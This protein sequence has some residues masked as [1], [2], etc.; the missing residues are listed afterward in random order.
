[1]NTRLSVPL[2]LLA[3]LAA[4]A[5][6]PAAALAD[7][8]QDNK[9]LWRNGTLAGAAAALYGLHNH[10]TTTTVLGAAG[11]AYSAHRY[12]E[13]RHSQDEA[14]RARQRARYYRTYTNYGAP[15]H[16]YT[17]R[18][19]HTTGYTRSYASGRHTSYRGRSRRACRCPR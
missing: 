9:N 6:A 13:D 14:Q 15:T 2:G 1:M 3:A 4:A 17:R 10:D 18:Y 8:Q 5:F 12:E 19:Y 16:F 7:S 11:A